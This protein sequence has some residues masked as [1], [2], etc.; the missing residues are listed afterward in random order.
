MRVDEQVISNECK[1][2]LILAEWAV[3][4]SYVVAVRN[5]S[6]LHMIG[7]KP[8]GVRSA[9]QFE[10]LA[11]SQLLGRREVRVTKQDE[12]IRPQVDADE[13]LLDVLVL[14]NSLHV[15]Q[16]VEG[17][18]FVAG[19][20]IDDTRSALAIKDAKRNW[21]ARSHSLDARRCADEAYDLLGFCGTAHDELGSLA[22]VLSGEDEKEAGV[23]SGQVRIH[24]TVSPLS[25]I[26]KRPDRIVWLHS[27]QIPLS[28]D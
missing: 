7:V 9:P 2:P 8:V 11:G 24:D 22:S 4:V 19:F 13:L 6:Y 27:P 16:A 21:G 10:A 3:R 25:E 28:L 23:V 18:A 14:D 17:S 5:L 15:G 26:A 1:A 12:V 20:H